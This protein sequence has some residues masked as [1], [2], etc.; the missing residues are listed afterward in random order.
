[1]IGLIRQF[2]KQKQE[3][4]EELRIY[5]KDK[6]IPLEDRWEAFKLSKLGN[7]DSW[8][9]TFESLNVLYSGE[10]SWYDDFYIDKYQTV[11]MVDLVENL[12][13]SNFTEKQIDAVK[14]EVLNTFTL[15]FVNDW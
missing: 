15:S 7:T 3:L 5:V 9:M 6:V 10:V 11:N 2:N 8:V 1:M 4:T 12:Y 13:E 14:G